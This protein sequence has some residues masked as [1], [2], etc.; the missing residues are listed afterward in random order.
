MHP[1]KK[2]QYLPTPIHHLCLHTLKKYQ[3]L[4]LKPRPC[5]P[6]HYIPAFVPQNCPCPPPP[7]IDNFNVLINRYVSW[8]SNVIPQRRSV[9]TLM[10]SYHKAGELTH[11]CPHTT[12]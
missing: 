4:V 11:Y 12:R 2:K 8:H 1:L 6:N 9:S 7:N 3:V 5:R 10:S